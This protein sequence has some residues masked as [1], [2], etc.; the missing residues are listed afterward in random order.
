MCRTGDG[1]RHTDIEQNYAAPPRGLGTD[2]C[3]A[4][5]W[6][7][8]EW[9]QTQ[10]LISTYAMMVLDYAEILSG[11]KFSSALD[12]WSSAPHCQYLRKPP[13]PYPWKVAGRG[14]LINGL[15]DDL[16]RKHHSKST[17]VLQCEYWRHFLRGGD[18]IKIILNK[19]PLAGAALAFSFSLLSLAKISSA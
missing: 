12:M 14:C 11:D 6:L 17:T 18:I 5:Q 9:K 7:M 3:A 16:H 4:W 13:T 10:S 2:S 19:S 15:L 1:V 8:M